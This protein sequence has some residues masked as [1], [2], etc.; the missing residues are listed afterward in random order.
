MFNY[1]SKIDNGLNKIIEPINN[2]TFKDCC[3]NPAWNQTLQKP[4]NL[5]LLGY[6]SVCDNFQISDCGSRPVE[7]FQKLLNPNLT[8]D[9]SDENFSR[10]E[11]FQESIEVDPINGTPTPTPETGQGGTVTFIP[12]T[13]KILKTPENRTIIQTPG[14]KG[15]NLD[16]KLLFLGLGII[17][18]LG[19]QK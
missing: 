19:L 4:G 10:L 2:E 7:K 1:Q 11:E 3:N 12:F 13:N 16:P 6:P 15:F 18:F 9:R 8:I 5:Y 17:L 14:V